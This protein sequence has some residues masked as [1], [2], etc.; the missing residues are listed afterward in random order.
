MNS[1][2]KPHSTHI[3]PL[4][5]A[6]QSKARAQLLRSAGV[7]FDVEPVRIDEKEIR[8]ALLQEGQGPR[9]IATALAELKGMRA[10]ARTERFVIGADQILSLNDE[11][12]GKSSTVEQARS[13]LLK[14]RGQVHEL[15]AAVCVAKD[16]AVIWRNVDTAELHMR[17]FSDS[18]L[19][20]YLIRNA[21]RVTKSVGG[22]QIEGEGL[23]LFDRI[24]GDYF[25]IL[26]LPLLDLLAFL[27]LHGMLLE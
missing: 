18:F 23:Q 27:R 24:K 15:T 14:L 5:L 8:T 25:T 11:I 1:V 22:Y 13:Q 16:G 9:E 2:G 7:S 6:S 20:D 4:I 3:A 26:G 10:S 21:D 12:L 19:D 17:T